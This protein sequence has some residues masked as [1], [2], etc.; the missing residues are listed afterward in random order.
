M[1]LEVKIAKRAHKNG[2]VSYPAAIKINQYDLNMKFVKT[3]NSRTKLCKDLK[4]DKETLYK[5]CREEKKS[6]N[7]FIYRYANK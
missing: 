3:Y 6:H 1:S 7:G 5:V 2:Q 4:I